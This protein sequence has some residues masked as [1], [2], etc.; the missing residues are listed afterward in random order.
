M[1]C[2]KCSAQLP[3]ESVCCFRCAYPTSPNFSAASSAR[4]VESLEY[5]EE[6]RIR[7][8]PPEPVIVERLVEKK[9]EKPAQPVLAEKIVGSLMLIG[10]LLLC[11]A[12][13]VVVVKESN[14]IK[15]GGVGDSALNT[16][17]L[18]TQLAYEEISRTT[19]PA[20]APKLKRILKPTPEPTQEPQA[21]LPQVQ[22]IF[23]DSLHVPASNI[24]S[25]R[26]SLDEPALVS[27]YFTAQGG[28]ND[29]ECFIVSEIDFVNLRNGNDFRSFYSSGNVTIGKI[30]ANLDAGNYYLVFR[31][32]AMFTNKTVK[33]KLSSE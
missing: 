16:S 30:S 25:K 32:Q 22:T 28:S 14:L 10:L 3:D 19:T 7:D 24:L 2:V 23:D 13:L 9:N 18:S 33:T 17:K 6:T 20:P 12:G 1:I 27:G 4:R 15:S 8:K 31:N 5:E 26:F 29:I 21:Y 11:V